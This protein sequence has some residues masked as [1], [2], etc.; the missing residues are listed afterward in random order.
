MLFVVCEHCVCHL[1]PADCLPSSPSCS[2]LCKKE[3][4]PP[5]C[6]QKVFAKLNSLGAFRP[7]RG[8]DPPMQSVIARPFLLF[9]KPSCAPVKCGLIKPYPQRVVC[10]WP[11]KPGRPTGRS[12]T[13][14][15]LLLFSLWYLF[16]L[17]QLLLVSCSFPWLSV[18]DWASQIQNLQRAGG[19][20]WRIRAGSPSTQGATTAHLPPAARPQ[21]R[22]P[23]LVKSSDFFF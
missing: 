10:P 22:W 20:R 1:L 17:Y 8:P 21:D 19:K 4:S 14:L 2:E 7:R 11:L 6:L 18:F 15:Q 12:H 23:I 13:R 9:E 5:F 16:L 3:H